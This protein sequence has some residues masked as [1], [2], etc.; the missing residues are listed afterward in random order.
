VR[1]PQLFKDIR[2]VGQAEG[3]RKT[4]HVFA[5]SDHYLVVA[6]N[7]RGGYNLSVVSLR[8]PEV[9]ARRFK[10]KR[11][12]T[13]IVRTGSKRPDLFGPDFAALSSLY[14]MVALHRAEKLKQKLGKSLVFKI[15]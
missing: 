10:G 11:V 13:R 12:T 4:Y 2:Y 7:S 1:I 3:E 15:K 8:A 6:P 14:V 5:A 9:I